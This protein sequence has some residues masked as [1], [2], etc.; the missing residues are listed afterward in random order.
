MTA[1][2]D[3]LTETQKRRVHRW[4]G[5]SGAPALQAEA[6]GVSRQAIMES[7][8]V[9]MLKHPAIREAAWRHKLVRKRTSDK[10]CKT[11][12]PEHTSTKRDSE[13]K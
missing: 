7:L 3:K 12:S 13:G 1:D 11:I 2:W 8:T 5:R 10:V 4:F 6:E 9:A